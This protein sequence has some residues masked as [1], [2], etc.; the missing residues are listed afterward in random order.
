MRSDLQAVRHLKYR[1]QYAEN[2]QTD[3]SS[4]YHDD[5]RRDQLR[6]YAD[7][8]IEFAL[9][10]VGDSLHGLGEMAGLFAY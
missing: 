7:A 8:P 6:D 3:Q 9:I 2:N 4:D 10:N 1:R 5:Y